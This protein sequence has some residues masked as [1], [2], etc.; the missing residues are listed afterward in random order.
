MRRQVAALLRTLKID[1]RREKRRLPLWRLIAGIEQL[2]EEWTSIEYAWRS[3]RSKNKASAGK[4]DVLKF[5][6]DRW[7]RATREPLSFITLREINDLAEYAL[8]GP[9]VV[10]GRAL[11]RLDPKTLDGDAFD[12]LLFA[13]WHGLREYLG[14]GWFQ[15]ILTRRGQRYPDAILEAVRDGNLESVLDEHLWISRRLRDDE[16]EGLARDLLGALG[17]RMGNHFV[18]APGSRPFPV[19]CHAAMPFSG[20]KLAPVADV[21]EKQLRTDQLRRAF[22]TPFW[23]HVLTTTSLGQEGLDF[24]V[25]CRRLLHW[26]LGSTPVDLEQREGRLQRFGALSIRGV[27]A[28]LLGDEALNRAQI[29][30]STTHVTASPWAQIAELAEERLPGNGSGLSPW[31]ICDGGEPERLFTPLRHSRQSAK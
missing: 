23:P 20:A 16:S 18:H 6:V 25:W 19:R 8:C 24:H 1:V 28:N 26:D 17:L 9:G 2:T 21:D 12:D 13:S 7:T 11:Y 30:G 31:W 4:R 14:N 10:L 29:T 15:S 22:N 5:L 3:V 27:L